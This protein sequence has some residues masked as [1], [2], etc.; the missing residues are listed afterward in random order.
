MPTKVEK[1]ALT[2]IETT[3]HEWDGIQELNNPLPKWWI[4]VFAATVVWS[5]VWMVLYDSIPYVTGHSQGVLGSDQRT[6]LEQKMEAARERQGVYLQGIEAA[7]VEEIVSDAELLSFANAGGAAAFADNCAPCHG[8]G[9]AGQAG[10]YPVLADDD[11]IWGGGLQDI[12]STILHGVRNGGAD[13][14][15]SYMPAFDW[16][17][18]DEVQA[19]ANY[20]VTLSGETAEEP[21]LV[22]VGGTLFAENCAA[23]HGDDG[24]GLRELGGPNL[25]DAIWLYGGGVEH[26][27]AQLLNPQHGVMPGF[28]DRLDE[29]TIKMLTVYVHQLGGGE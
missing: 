6:V 1:D 16:M 17:E 21:S 8:L 9:G 5:V 10:V 24:K 4:Y 23:C 27:A 13:A 15:E 18:R 26:V 7:S 28:G 3:G 14:R 12:K 29:S 22:D 2:G 25:T 20:V 19:I 11:W